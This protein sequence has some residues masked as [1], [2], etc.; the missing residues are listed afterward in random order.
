MTNIDATGT[1]QV[2]AVLIAAALYAATYLSFVRLLRYP[3]NWY[4]PSLPSSLVTG[5]LAI[6]TVA[7]VTLSRDGLDPAA[8]LVSTGFIAAMACVIGA[9]AV[10]FR[11]G[12]WPVIGFL[13]QH[14]A[15]ASLCMLGP[16]MIAGYIVPNGKLQG[17]LAV[18]MTIEL[19]WF[20]RQSW[21]NGRQLY[22]LG[23]HDV[24]VMTTQAKGDLA[25]FAKKH[26]IRELVLSD[27]G[28]GWLGCGKE[29]LPCPF[30]ITFTAS[31]STPRPAVE[32]TWRIFATM[33]LP[34]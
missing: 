12:R 19:A 17:V 23:E 10:N 27:G 18:A 15:L 11:P 32:S 16:A 21:T 26:G 24:L 2:V 13:S 30:T 3:R 20:M 6:L 1:G 22:P 31:A 8:L 5:F 25:G 9:P 33:S 34:A 29:T 14:G 28:V 7:R 4:P